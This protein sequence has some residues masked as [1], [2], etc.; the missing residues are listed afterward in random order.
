MRSHMIPRWEKLL[1]TK[2]DFDVV[3]VS[4]RVD[5][6]CKNNVICNDDNQWNGA[7]GAQGGCAYHD[8]CANPRNCDYSLNY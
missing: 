4:E 1:K 2:V 7:A 3:C 6:E 5:G 8:K